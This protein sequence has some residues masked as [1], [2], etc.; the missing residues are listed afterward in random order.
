MVLN[1]QP[2]KTPK[3]SGLF[4]RFFGSSKD[5]NSSKK[6]DPAS[7][8]IKTDDDLD[9]SE[10]PNFLQMDMRDNLRGR[11]MTVTGSMSKKMVFE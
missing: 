11:T 5:K 3:K 9:N 6:K 10:E 1:P 8:A 7:L 4:S 2:A